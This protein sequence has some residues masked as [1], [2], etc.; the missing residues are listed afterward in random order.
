MSYKDAQ[1]LL[2][3]MVAIAIGFVLLVCA[4]VPARSQDA[5]WFL[6]FNINGMTVISFQP[7]NSK[8]ACHLAARQVNVAV[9]DCLEAPSQ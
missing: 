5:R 7:F 9:F 4:L 1:T 8:E 3:C 2:W 6:A